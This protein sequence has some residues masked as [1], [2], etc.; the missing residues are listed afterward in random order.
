[1]II[2]VIILAVILIFFWTSYNAL[3]TRKNRVKNAWS[4][5]DVQLKR[6]YDLIPNLV[7]TVKGYAA[8]ERELFEKVTQAR[9]SAMSAKT[10]A[11]TAQANN[12]LSETLKTL[13]AVAENYPNLKA[14]EN[15]MRLQEELAATENKIAFAR[16]FYNDEA[17]SYKITIERFPTNIIA[18]IFRFTPEDFFHIPEGE[19]EPVKVSFTK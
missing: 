6:R 9:A 5:I 3:V 1:M 2:L 4:Q 17:M 15:F 8:H 11:D 7:E 14:N 13:F 12:A 10:V 18:G 19:K 16:Q